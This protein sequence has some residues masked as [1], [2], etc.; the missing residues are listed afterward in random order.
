MGFWEGRNVVVPGGCGAI[1]SYAVEQLVDAGAS[2]AVI[3]NFDTGRHE[4]IASVAGAVELIEGDVRDMDIAR[5]AFHGKDTVLNFAAQA[6]GVGHSHK[7]HASLLGDNAM[8]CSSVLEAARLEKVERVL[9]ISSS[10]VYPD[11]APVPTPEM[12]LCTG[13]P[14]HVNAGYG[15]AKRYNEL[16]SEYYARHFGMQIALG[17][18]FNAYGARDLAKGER[19]H[20]IPA[21]IEKLL[22]PS[23]ELVVW[24]SGT[25]TRSFIHARDVAN[26]LLLLAEKHAVCDPVNVG[27]DHETSMRELVELLMEIS[28]IRKSIVF[29]RSKPEG[30]LRKSAD[31]TKFREV[32]APFEPATD[33]RQGLKEMIEAHRQLFA[34]Q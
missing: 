29:D 13:G 31:M 19:S 11:D 6:P 27:H 33:L 5:R 25:Q 1:G 16:L 18:P 4:N 23:S 22:S 2:L 8:I 15:W 10:C 30:C 7:N 34:T 28:G 17:R 26:G 9:T 32:V 12:P 14:E 3:D 20:V 21:L 24:G